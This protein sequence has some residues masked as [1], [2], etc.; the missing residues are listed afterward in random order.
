MALEFAADPTVTDA[1]PLAIEPGDVLVIDWRPV[2]EGV[3]GDVRRG[4]DVSVI[5]A[6]FHNSLVEG[7]LGV[8]QAVGQPRVALSGG[9]F[10]NKRLVEGAIRRLEPAGFEVLLHSAVPAN[11]GG[12]SLGQIAVAAARLAH[13]DF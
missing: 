6:R 3:V 1:Y 7:M 8:A 4:R 10:Q 5:A 2:I 13:K 12:V 9:C 11:D